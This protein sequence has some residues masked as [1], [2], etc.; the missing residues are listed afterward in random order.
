MILK[1]RPGDLDADRDV[2]V[3]LLARHVNPAYD[4]RRFDW[5]YRDAPAG[6]G[7]LW[8]A[9]DG[10]T[11]GVVGVAGAFPR[12]MLVEGRPVPAWVLGDFC[13]DDAH[14][15]L[16]PALQL[17]RACLD[18]LAGDEMA[19][20]YDFPSRSMEAVY[21]R[22]GILPAH[23]LRRL[24]RPLRVRRL[25][26]RR[27]GAWLGGSLGRL[28]DVGLGWAARSGRRY[29]GITVASH[30]GRCGPEFSA[31]TQLAASAYRVCGDRSAQYVN[32]RYLDNPMQPHELL[33]AR[34]GATLVGWVAVSRDGEAATL[35]DLFAIPERR[36]VIALIRGAIAR[37][38][39]QGA[40]SVCFEM[41]GSHPWMSGLGRLGLRP[42]GDSPV[43]VYT[44]P[45]SEVG[46]DILRHTGWF[47][48]HGDRDG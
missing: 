7:R 3:R 42:R 46:G 27:G 14:R 31:L 45:G 23:R 30:A 22:L 44:R 9:E 13:I 10:S 19:F 11:G 5:L 41:T 1:I 15:T 38:W 4:R 26:E 48:T 34:I 35:V 20:C 40:A 24:V 43:A 16:G 17:Q 29:R 12:R 36:V 47:L 32:W 37:L 25:L 21:R 18:D 33:T 2:T 6:V 39:A 28:V 8:V